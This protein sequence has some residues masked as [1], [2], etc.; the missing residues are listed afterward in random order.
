M[1]LMIR[2]QARL[3]Y[4]NG[5]IRHLRHKPLPHHAI[6]RRSL[7]VQPPVPEEATHPFDVMLD[8]L[9]TMEYSSQLG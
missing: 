5:R 3:A 1:S 7:G 2:P 9:G 4:Q 8:Q 6:D